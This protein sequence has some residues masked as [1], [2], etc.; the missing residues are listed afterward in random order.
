MIDFTLF[1]CRMVIFDGLLQDLTVF[2]W[3]LEPIDGQTRSYREWIEEYINGDHESLY[4]A[5]GIEGDGGW[6]VVFTATIHCDSYGCAQEFKDHIEVHLSQ[7][8]PLPPEMLNE[9]TTLPL[10]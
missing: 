4:P 1:Y 9:P 5:L 3:E 10:E 6:E 7:V 2:V 8:Q